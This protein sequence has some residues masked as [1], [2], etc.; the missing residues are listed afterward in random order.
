MIQSY[1]VDFLKMDIKSLSK[2][3]L[4]FTIKRVAEIIGIFFIIIGILLF[5]ALQSVCAQSLIYLPLAFVY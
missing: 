4:G 5:L 3:T 1:K 2:K